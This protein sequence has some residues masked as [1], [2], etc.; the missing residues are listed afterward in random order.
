MSKNI[1]ALLV[2]CQKH[3]DDSLLEML[4]KFKPLLLKYS[5]KLYYE[6]AYNDLQLA[7][8]EIIFAI[9]INRFSELPENEP[10][11]IAYLSKSLYTRY[12]QL[13]KK[14]Q[15]LGKCLSFG[16]EELLDYFETTYGDDVDLSEDVKKYMSYLTPMQQNVIL[17]IY[18]KG[19]NDAE[20]ARKLGI[21]RQAV[22]RTKYRALKI[23]R[24][25]LTQ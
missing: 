17:N 8:I 9:P 13:S 11:I 25:Y 24:E 22:G 14:D 15:D 6:D 4:G 20:I 16:D 21:S 3:D 10:Q 12:I 7:F 19:Y 2:N 5:F 23:L 1:Y 18:Y